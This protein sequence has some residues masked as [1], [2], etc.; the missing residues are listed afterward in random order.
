MIKHYDCEKCE[1][2]IELVYEVG[3]GG[4]TKQL[5]CKYNIEI[6]KYDMNPNISLELTKCSLYRD[7]SL[8]YI[9]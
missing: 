9:K 7:K 1:N 4:T 8:R 6:D 3:S 5:K 2:N